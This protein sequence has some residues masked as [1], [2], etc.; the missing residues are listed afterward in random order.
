[1]L[2]FESH[3]KCNIFAIR[4]SDKVLGF[5]YLSVIIFSLS[6]V[7][8]AMIIVYMAVHK[9]EKDAEKYTFARYTKRKQKLKM[10]RRIMVQGI[11]YSAALATLCLTLILAFAI[12]QLDSYYAVEVLAA[13]FYSLQGFWNGLI[14]MMPLFRKFVKNRCKSQQNDSGS[15]HYDQNTSKTNW[16]TRLR[17]FWK[18]E[19]TS[20]DSKNSNAHQV[21]SQDEESKKEEDSE[22]HDGVGVLN[23]NSS[24]KQ[25][26]QI[27]DVNANDISSLSNNNK[28]AMF[29]EIEE[30]GTDLVTTST[31]LMLSNAEQQEEAGAE[32]LSFTT[33]LSQNSELEKKRQS[34]LEY[35]SALEELNNEYND[36]IDDGDS[37]SDDESYVDDYLRMMRTEW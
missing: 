19:R 36:N 29:K 11:L 20:K 18:H 25:E 1:M 12:A 33:L 26:E 5:F 4:S 31:S 8:I 2:L 37:D 7:T 15:V 35:F 3:M 17:T 6:Y 30:E 23:V 34:R 28:K 14:Y 9:V 16:L 10:S 13:I 27:M 21:R 22:D 32:S 24:R